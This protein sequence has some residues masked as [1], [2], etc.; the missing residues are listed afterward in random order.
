VLVGLI[1]QRSQVQIL[2]PQQIRPAWLAA[3]TLRFCDSR[4]MT[5]ISLEQW[6]WYAVFGV[7]FVTAAAVLAFRSNR[8][9]R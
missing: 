1:T 5:G 3:G 2:S 9:S 8:R 4:L 7:L 6:I